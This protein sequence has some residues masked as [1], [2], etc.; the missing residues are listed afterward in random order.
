M[1]W[2]II[3]ALIGVGFA[4]G[5]INT[6]AG[7]GSMLTL[8]LLMFLGLPANIANGTNRIAILF[9]NIIGVNTFRKN[10]ILNLK[11]DYRLAIPATAGSIIGAMFAVE[12]NEAIMQKVIAVVM[13]IML[14]MVVFKPESRL[15]AKADRQAAK[16]S[17]LQYIIFFV[18]G[19]YGGFIQLG[20]GFLL[21][22]GLVWGCGFDLI[23]TNAVKVFIILSYTIFALAI[24]IWNRQ[25]DFASG[26]I[27]ASG[28]MTG[29]WFGA[30]F[31]IKG[32][33]KY[34]RYILIIALV[35]V[36][37]KLLGVF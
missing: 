3:P 19:L 34:V 23:K 14:F 30:K 12:L 22:A 2:Y 33:A 17:V 25:V 28:N 18:I 7:G 36:T 11:K 29:A 9:Q 26:L 27:L 35:I 13:V 6:V 10:K 31:T 8:P 20:I 32:G 16:P 15:K 5:F 37:V 4:A 1:E 21:I 24:F